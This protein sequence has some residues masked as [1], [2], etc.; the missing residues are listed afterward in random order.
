MGGL[1]LFKSHDNHYQHV[2][3]SIIIY[4]YIYQPLQKPRH[5]K[6]RNCSVLGFSTRLLSQDLRFHFGVPDATLAMDREH[7]V[8]RTGSGRRWEREQRLFGHPRY[9]RG[10]WEESSSGDRHTSFNHLIS[11]NI[12]SIYLFVCLTIYLLIPIQSYLI[13]S[14]YVSIYCTSRECVE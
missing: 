5:M 3:E 6:W 10:W 2:L 14:I 1:S 4:L 11:I 13:L 7:L 8:G 12:N 9:P